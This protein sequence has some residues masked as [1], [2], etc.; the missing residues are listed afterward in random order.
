MEIPTKLTFE[1]AVKSVVNLVVTP[2]NDEKLNIYSLY[3][4]ATVGDINIPKPGFFDFAGHAKWNAWN[5]AIGKTSEVAKAEYV[6]F[7][8]SLITKY[9]LINT[10]TIESV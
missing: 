7:V 10:P 1:V 9:G 4:Q 5:Q 6:D 3:K 2:T 8:M